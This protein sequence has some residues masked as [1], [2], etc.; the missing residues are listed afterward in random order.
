MLLVFVLGLLAG[1]A[2]FSLLAQRKGQ[3]RKGCRTAEKTPVGRA[4][5]RRDYKLAA[6]KQCTPFFRFQA[7]PPGSA[8]MANFIPEYAGTL[9]DLF[10]WALT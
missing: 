5:N 8:Q 4:C 10:C 3:K 2:P 6:L 1:G 9:Y 7:L